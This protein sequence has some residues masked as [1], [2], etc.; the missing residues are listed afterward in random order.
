MEDVKDKIKPLVLISVIKVRGAGLSEKFKTKKN[1][2]LNRI[3]DGFFHKNFRLKDIKFPGY[4]CEDV[5]IW[6]PQF[7]R[8]NVLL[9]SQKHRKKQKECN[10]F[11]LIH[12]SFLDHLHD[13]LVKYELENYDDIKILN[14]ATR[15]IGIEKNILI[16]NSG[17]ELY[18]FCA[19][20]ELTCVDGTKEDLMAKE[21]D[22]FAA[23]HVCLFR[24]HEFVNDFL[25]KDGHVYYFENCTES[26]KTHLKAYTLNYT[27]LVRTGR[28]KRMNK[29]KKIEAVF[30]KT[31]TESISN[32]Y[33][34]KML[35]DYEWLK[36][37]EPDDVFF[38]WAPGSGTSPNTFRVPVV[39]ELDARDKVVLE[40][41]HVFFL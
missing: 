30:Y 4:G 41:K 27:H 2:F 40:T 12:I 11:Y 13:D 16:R 9:F 22:G 1:L 31:F 6:R 33:G 38:G 5:D 32:M 35:Q 28:A 10:S 37:E 39:K 19:D 25:V 15:F 8:G 24:H 26:S 36:K 7:Q 3:E 21:V 18:Q 23:P 34:G 20:A 29:K 14:H 17:R